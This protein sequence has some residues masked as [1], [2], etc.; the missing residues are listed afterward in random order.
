LLFLRLLNTLTHSL[1]HSPFCRARRHQSI[2][3]DILF[4]IDKGDLAALLDLS[5][6]FDTVDR[7]VLLK[8]LQITFGIDGLAWFWFRSYLADRFQHVRSHSGLSLIDGPE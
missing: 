5:A 3:A 7:D 2:L 4:A 8:R 1:T 6:A